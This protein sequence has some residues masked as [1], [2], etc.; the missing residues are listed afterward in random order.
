MRNFILY[1]LVFLYFFSSKNSYSESYGTVIMYHRFEEPNLPSTSI[2]LK[3]FEGHLTYLKENNF[4]VLPLSKLI[5]YFY[6]EKELPKK[7][8]FI[9]VDDGYKSFYEKAYPLLLK[10][11]Y[12][13]SIFVSTDYVSNNPDSNFMNWEMLK[14]IQNNNGSIYNHTSDHSNL[15]KIPKQEK[16]NV[17]KKASKELRKNLRDEAKIFSY[18]YGIS[19][20][21]IES[22][23]PDLGYDLAFGQ[24][25]S[26]IHKK[27]NRFR[28][29]RFAFNEEF[30]SIDRFKLIVNSF[31]I[32]A[33]DLI[34]QDTKIKNTNLRLGF[35]TDQDISSINCYHSSNISLKT[36]KIEPS[37]I[38]IQML[39][40]PKKGINRINCT[41]QVNGKLFWYGRILIN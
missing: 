15:N 22:I 4:N 27:E 33:Y 21:E 12:P 39:S 37:R 31:P 6:N 7:S 3:T 13:F 38:E 5:D 29:P 26:H 32:Q 35:S 19:D 11:N 2:S 25:S 24:Q 10:F 9:T 36:N 28:L 23:L 14:E 1:S 17:I 30:G 34:P 8:I 18:P 20:L 16:L 41:S 40:A